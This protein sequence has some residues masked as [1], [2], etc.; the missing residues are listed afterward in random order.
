MHPYWGGD[1]I[2]L[3]LGVPIV[4]EGTPPN[5]YSLEGLIQHRLGVAH[6]DDVSGL[7]IHLVWL[8]R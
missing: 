3:I 2:V 8:I 7:A 6:I 4:L 5:A 1:D